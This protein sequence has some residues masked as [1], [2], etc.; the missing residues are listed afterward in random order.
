MLTGVVPFDRTTPVATAMAHVNDTPPPV[1]EVRP[2]VPP[3]YAATTDACLA[4]DPAA[5]PDSAAAVADALRLS[6]DPAFAPTTPIPP[7]EEGDPGTSTAVLGTGAH[8]E[9]DDA[10]PPTRTAQLPPAEVVAEPDP[11]ATV[12]ARPR[13]GQPRRGLFWI[14]IGAAVAVALILFLVS[15]LGSKATSLPNLTGKGLAYA[16]DV[17]GKLGLEVST[18]YRYSSKRPNTVIGTEP[19][20]GAEVRTG[21]RLVL[22][23]SRGP[24]VVEVPSLEGEPFDEDVMRDA[25]TRAGLSYEG[26]APVDGPAG[27]VVGTDPPA[28]QK[29][30]P[31]TSVTVLVGKDRD[32]GH[33]RKKK[34]KGNDGGDET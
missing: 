12:A 17:G 25:L 33:D 7:A 2:D 6:V 21:D 20:A 13:R 24:E 8:R 22:L 5:R 18:T 31:G 11:E 16:K 4:K 19:E 30:S 3:A 34:R 15:R 27:I 9:D 29:V 23:V 14:L 26:F 10:A 28:G 1:L 32:R